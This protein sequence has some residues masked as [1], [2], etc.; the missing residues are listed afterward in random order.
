MSI[1]RTNDVVISKDSIGIHTY[2]NSKNR[3]FFRFDED[4]QE[5]TYYDPYGNMMCNAPFQVTV[6]GYD[7][8]LNKLEDEVRLP[9]GTMMVFLPKLVIQ[10]IANN[11]FYQ[12]KQFRTIDFLTNEVTEQ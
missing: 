5:V 10:E 11:T 6:Q 7:F 4:E 8:K 3:A 1:K 12:E 2:F 9:D